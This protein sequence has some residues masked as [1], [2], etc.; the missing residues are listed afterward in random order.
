LQAAH[1]KVRMSK[2]DGP[3]VIRVNIVVVAHFGQSG[4][5]RGN[6]VLRLGSGGSV[7]GSQSPLEAVMGGDEPCMQPFAGAPLFCF[8]HF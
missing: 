8:A 4:R 3:G 1:S 7:T 5:E 6:M 2:P